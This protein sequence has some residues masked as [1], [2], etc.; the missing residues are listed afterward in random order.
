[1]GSRYSMAALK[2]SK[3]GSGT[4]Q[5]RKRL[6][7]DVRLDYQALYG[8]AHE[9]KGTIPADT[10]LEK[11]KALH[12]EFHALIDNR[13]AALR[14]GKGST[15]VDLTQ[16]EADAWAGDW[17]RWFT[18][19]HLDNPGSPQ[20]WDIIR[21]ELWSMAGEAGDPQTREAD[22]ADPEV[23]SEVDTL[24]R[25]SQFLTDRGV[26]LTPAGRT[27]FLS[28]VVRE[29]LEA[30][31]TLERA[32][33]GDRGRDHHLDQLEPSPLSTLGPAV[34]TSPSRPNGHRSEAVT[35]GRTGRARLPSAMALFEL[36]C[37]D[38]SLK[39]STIID[40]RCVFTALDKEDWR[41]PEW[42]AQHWLD[43]LVTSRKP[44]TVRTK[45]L[46]PAHALFN[47]VRRKRIKDAEGRLL[48]ETNPFEGCSITVPKRR[49]T[50]A[51]GK[52]FTDEETQ[53]ILRA[54]T[55]LG[56]PVGPPEAMQRWVPWLLAYTGARGGEIT[57]LRV[58]DIEQHRACGPALLITPDAG[59]QKTDKARL[60]PIHLH[61]IEMG[62]LDYVAAVEAR[63]GKSGPL[64]YRP[65][66]KPS[67]RHP[68][69]RAREKLA[70][71]VRG[72]GIKDKGVQPLHGLRHTFLTRA[73]RARID[74]RIR[75]EIV[76]HVPR[77][78]A[79]QY[80]HPSIEDMAVALKHFPRYEVG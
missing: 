25:A 44:Q 70:E 46:S 62:L 71:W 80:E 37:G 31:K 79:D 76:G 60:V 3:S 48:V 11:A 65:R 5:L 78:V 4:F 73:T 10:P 77:T 49:I 74:P 6:P 69:V 14:A 59:T 58:Q 57:Q 66:T 7:A 51:T 17:Y 8:P 50:R 15:G 1:M 38:R 9:V 26:A 32:A 41:A 21:Y 64:F 68:A 22:F 67:S 61:L 30:T 27:I 72:Q 28:A 24:A 43:T 16:R 33:G 40:H 75:D 53:T 29:F 47:W 39:P 42:D 20:D 35:G 18:S 2:R 34:A 52:A 54:S 23:L 45:W 12:A 13:I 19:Q 36:S 56:A 63:L 55:A